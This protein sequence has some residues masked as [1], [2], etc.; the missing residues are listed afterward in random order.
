MLFMKKPHGCL[1]FCVDYR[2]LNAVT[3]KVK[4]PLLNHEDL[5]DQL[6]GPKYFQVWTSEVGIGNARLL[7]IQYARQPS[8]QGMGIMSG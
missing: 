2:A 7:K 6:A 3:I 1:R 4:Y 8:L 5:T